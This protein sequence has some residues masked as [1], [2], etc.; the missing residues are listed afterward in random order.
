MTLLNMLLNEMSQSQRAG[1]NVFT[2][3]ELA[4]LLAKPVSPAFT[5]FLHDAVKKGMLVRVC[6]G[7]FYSS[8]T[9]PD[10][11]NILFDVAKKLRANVF[12]YISLESQ[13]SYTGD[14]SQITI[15]RLTIMTKGRSAIIRT[16]FGTIEFVHTK[17]SLQSLEDKVYFDDEIKMFRALPVLALADLKACRRNTHMLEKHNA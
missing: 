16:Q 14:I 11:S 12:S 17:K 10:F 4:Y 1:A 8:L 6:K 3:A 15:D 2:N 7:I 13:L 9:P 5:K